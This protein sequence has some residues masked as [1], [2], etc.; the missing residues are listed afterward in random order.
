MQLLGYPLPTK[1]DDG[2]LETPEGFVATTSGDGQLFRLSCVVPRLSAP[3]E[4]TVCPLPFHVLLF[5]LIPKGS[6]AFLLSSLPSRFPYPS[7]PQ[8]PPLPQGLGT[9]SSWGWTARCVTQLK[10]SS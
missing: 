8:Q 9:G 6:A 2:T 5:F 1:K 4:T 3:P 7:V 10:A